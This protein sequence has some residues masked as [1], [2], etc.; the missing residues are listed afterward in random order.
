M[1]P[2]KKKKLNFY[3]V[4]SVNNPITL[5]KCLHSCLLEGNNLLLLR[6]FVLLVI[7]VFVFLSLK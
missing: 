7:F 4:V 6:V 3:E 1:A 2:L 5:C